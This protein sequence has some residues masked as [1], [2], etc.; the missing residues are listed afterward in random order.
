MKIKI[1]RN[2][3]VPF[4]LYG[5]ET[6]SHAVRKERRPRVFENRVLRETERSGIKRGEEWGQWKKILCVEKFHDLDF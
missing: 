1:H 2:I 5:C 4:D 3:I 6:W